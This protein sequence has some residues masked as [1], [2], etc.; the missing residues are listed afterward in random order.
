MQWFRSHKL[1]VGASALFALAC[2]FAVTFGHVHLEQFS[3][4]ALLLAADQ[5]V[6]VATGVAAADQPSSPGHHGPGRVRNDY[7]AVCAGI[8]L[9]GAMLIPGMPSVLPWEAVFAELQWAY[10]P[11]IASSVGYFYFD[12]RGPPQG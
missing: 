4:S 11:A 9:A 1:T 10:A 8:G 5:P 6:P 3:G 2:H 7:C 12:A